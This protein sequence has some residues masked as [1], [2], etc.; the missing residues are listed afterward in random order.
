MKYLLLRENYQKAK[1]ILKEEEIDINDT[2]FNNIKNLL[3]KHTGY[4]GKFTEWYFKQ[5]TNIT[6]LRNLLNQI[7]EVGLDKSIDTFETAESLGDYLTKTM[8]DRKTKQ[9]LKSLP[10]RARR[11]VTD[12]LIDLIFNFP[13]Y[14]VNIKDFYS[15]KG[16]R[17]KDSDKLYSDTEILINNLSGGWGVEY[18]KYK[19][20]ELVYKDSSTLILHIKDYDRSCDLGSQ[21]W[22]ISTDKSMWKDYTEGFNKQYFIYDFSKSQSDKKSMIGVTIN[23]SGLISACYYKDDSEGDRNEILNEYGQ[24]LNPYSKEYIKGKID[25]NSIIEVSQYGFLDEVKRLIQQGVDP[26]DAENQAIRLS[27]MY[28]HLDVVKLLLKDPR[29]DPSDDSNEAIRLASENGHT[30]VVKELLKDPRVDP[31]DKNNFAIRSV[32]FNGYVEV[33][34]ELLKDPRVDPS[35]LGNGSI[36][37]SSENGHIDV[38]RELLK[39][40]RV[41]P[42]DMNNYAIRLSSEEGHIEVVRELLKD[43]RVDPSDIDNFAIRYSSELG[44]VEVVRELLKDDRVKSSLSKEDL[45]KYENQVK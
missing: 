36:R 30:D 6:Y 37:W 25:I 2:E 39:D 14:I 10:S 42:S 44:H 29:V 23:T 32:S 1:K 3:G 43:P 17:Y 24:Y 33:V 45:I 27:S 28:G 8:Y 31:S 40:P 13:Q 9:V 38:V 11:L 18:I 5:H 34:K 19:P 16:G 4:L 26:S 7:L 22:C 21:H 35:D 41:S 12:K 15:K 20:E